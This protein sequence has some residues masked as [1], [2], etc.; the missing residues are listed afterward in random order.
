[1]KSKTYV[2]ETDYCPNCDEASGKMPDGS[3]C[4]VC[5]GKGWVEVADD[6][7]LPL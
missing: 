6:V 1:M 2:P 4:P 7:S 5:K 3:E